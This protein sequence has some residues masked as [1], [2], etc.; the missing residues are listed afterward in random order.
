MTKRSTI[1]QADLQRIFR[2]AKATSSIVQIDLRKL[3]AT[4]HPNQQTAD[5]FLNGLAPDRPENWD[6]EEPPRKL[7][8]DFAL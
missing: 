5:E 7:S 1:R 2:A 6:D 4:V 8:D 3:V